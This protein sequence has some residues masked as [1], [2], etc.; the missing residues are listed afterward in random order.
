MADSIKRADFGS[1]PTEKTDVLLDATALR[2]NVSIDRSKIRA[3]AKLG[4]NT[5]LG[6]QDAAP[7]KYGPFFVNAEV[8]AHTAATA[9]YT[10]GAT[11]AKKFVV[12]DNV[13]KK[14]A[15][16]VVGTEERSITAINSSTGDITLSGA[17]D[18]LA[19]GDFMVLA[20]GTEKSESVVV[21][22]EELDVTVAGASDLVG[23]AIH[24][25]R[26]NENAIASGEIANLDKSKVQRLV[27]HKPQV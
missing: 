4:P 11:A 23:S 25:G 6:R 27:F 19:V 8:T 1:V 7:G 16:G 26:L 20:D 3:T 18:F 5:L 24:A 13:V 10:V 2:V 17:N 12:G 22:D 9:V 14:T 15:A 21:L